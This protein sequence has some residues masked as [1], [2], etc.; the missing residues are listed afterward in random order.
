MKIYI[1]ESDGHLVEGGEFTDLEEAKEQCID[2][3]QKERLD[4]L[5]IHITE[6]GDV[7]VDHESFEINNPNP[8]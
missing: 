7:D 2:F 4:S 6:D 8:L 1:I 3:M 5:T